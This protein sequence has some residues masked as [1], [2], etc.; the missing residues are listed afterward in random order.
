MAEVIKHGLIMDADYFD[1]LEANIDALMQRD[2]DAL[3]P[4]IL[5]SCE[6]KAAVVAADEREQGQ[7]ALL[8]F[9]HTFAHAIESVTGYSQWLH[10]E[11]VAIGMVMAARMSGLPDAA[12]Q[13]IAALLAAAGLPTDAGDI[14]GDALHAAMAHDKKVQ[15]GRVRLILLREIGDAFVT[16]DYD[17]A[18]L[19]AL[20]RGN[21]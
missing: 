5:R 8:N 3:R 18:R 2:D 4:A 15:A 20:L 1:W 9:G 7:R 6:I 16:S 12:Q 14:D 21:R 11:A 17:D 19:L 10:G 13:R